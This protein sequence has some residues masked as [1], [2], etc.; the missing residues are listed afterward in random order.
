MRKNQ[1]IT[2]IALI[3]TI[4]VMLILVGVVV[5]VVIQSDL[6]GTAKTAGNKYKTAYEDESNMSEV[7]INGEKYAS[8]EDYLEG[9]VKLPEIKAGERANVISKY[10]TAI[11]PAGFTVSK[12]PGETTVNEGLVIYDIPSNVDTTGDFWMITEKTGD[13]DSDDC[14]TVQKNYNQFVWVPVETPI[15]EATKLQ[16]LINDQT[17]SEVTNEQTAVD[18]IIRTEEKYPMAVELS[19]GNYRGI[20]YNFSEGADGKVEI[21]T[22]EFSSDAD[23]AYSG[24]EGKT[25]SREPAALSGNGYYRTQEEVQMEYNSIVKSQN[26]FW[27]ARYEMGYDAN[28]SKG[29][30]KRGQTISYDDSKEMYHTGC[31]TAYQANNKGEIQSSMIYGSQW[32]QIML[33]LKDIKN[34][35]SFYILDSNNMGNYMSYIGKVSGYKDNYGAKQIFDLAGNFLEFTMEISA[36]ND[37]VLR[38]GH[39]YRYGDKPASS[40]VVRC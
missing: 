25:Y 38:G 29:Q 16:E 35:E 1:G 40:R 17:K 33:W 18:Y 2:L 36:N 31:K 28:L 13:E 19:N 11:I 3:I 7:T 37:G 9:K 10:Q 6:L 8:I 5:T 20:L 27:V 4:I 12:I 21:T 32:D 30:S 34:G 39:F 24:D 15:V 26:G 22:L 23:I 14:Y